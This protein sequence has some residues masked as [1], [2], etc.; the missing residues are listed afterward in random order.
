M[1]TTQRSTLSGGP[2]LF[3]AAAV[4]ILIVDDHE[5]LRSGLRMLLE[6]EDDL[7]VC[8]EAHDEPT[9]K[10]MVRELQPAIAVVDLVLGNGSGLD[11]IQWMAKS[12]PETKSIVST[13]HDERIYGER[14]LRAGASGYVNK[15]APARTI[16]TAVRRVQEGKL[17]FSDELTAHIVRRTMS[18]QVP[19]ES[20]PL[21]A[22]SNR[23]LEVLSLIGQGLTSRQIALRLHLSPNTIHTYRERLKTK[24]DAP[25]GAELNRRAIQWVLENG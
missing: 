23:E 18:H 12:Q 10:R 13:M 21:D 2:T 5:L 24:L 15:N 9:A 25:N 20:S 8:G 4:H 6:T 14:A 1:T 17:F 3:D 7:H 22:L 11:L 19:L 16:I